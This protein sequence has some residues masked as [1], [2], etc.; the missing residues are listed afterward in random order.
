MRLLAFRSREV[1]TPHLPTCLDVAPYCNFINGFM[2]MFSLNHLSWYAELL[3][4]HFIPA[5]Q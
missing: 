2:I 1:F 4:N 5:E 3:I